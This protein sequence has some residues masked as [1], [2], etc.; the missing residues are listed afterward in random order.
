MHEDA[1]AEGFGANGEGV[2]QCA[3]DEGGRPVLGVVDEGDGEGGD[4]EG[5]PRVSAE[6][7]PG[8]GFVTGDDVAHQPAAPAE[9]FDKGDDEGAAGE[10]EDERDFLA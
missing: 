8:E 2:D 1:G 6:G 4:P 10:T 5:F 9:F 7:D 3:P